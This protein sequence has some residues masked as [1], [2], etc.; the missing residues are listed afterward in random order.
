M[1]LKVYGRILA[2]RWWIVL[3]N[4]FITFA[5]TLVLTFAEPPV[6][7]SSATF[8]L[9]LG[10]SFQD[11]KGFVSALDILSRRAEIAAT[12]T[13][14][15]T[16]RL[17]KRQ[18][19]DMMGLTAAE[20]GD[21]SVSSRAVGGTNVL[22]ISVEGLDPV[23]ARD[24]TDAIGAQ[25]IAYVRGLYETYELEPL[26]EAA[27][28]TTPIS[29]NYAL[30]LGLGAALGLCLGVGLAFLAEYL[31]AAPEQRT[32]FDILDDETGTYSRRYFLFRLQQ[33]L[34]RARRVAAPLAVALMNID[35]RGVME[36]ATPQLRHEALRQMTTRLAADLREE[37][38]MAR[39]DTTVIAFLFPDLDGEAAKKTIA[40]MQSRI[41]AAPVEV[42]ARGVRL[43]LQG[44]AGIVACQGS[45]PDLDELLARVTHALEGA[46]VAAYDKVQL[47][48]ESAGRRNR[49]G[50]R[51]SANGARP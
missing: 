17:I 15:A 29:P 33:E 45:A 4:L 31:R 32:S 19:A 51:A 7:R 14:V 36:G 13:E 48:A 47:H 21:L 46:E 3:P 8:V 39:F 26:D 41:A 50:A 27:L 10:A 12:Y 2:R 34:S 1:E 35:H 6:Y 44:A 24:F 20:R 25:T 11:D 28:R 16:S 9:K 18:A 37:D 5:A 38:T 40:A 42:V 22:E 43:N 23:L 30:N 49:A